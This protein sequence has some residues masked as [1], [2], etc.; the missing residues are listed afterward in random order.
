MTISLEDIEN[1]L[2]EEDIEGLIET[3]A[4]QDEYSSE[5]RTIGEAINE[6]SGEELSGDT[7]MSIISLIWSESFNLSE[8]DIALRLPSIRSTTNKILS[9]N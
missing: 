6:M 8:E 1:I 3:G 9:I 7:L 2:R 5:A 4:P